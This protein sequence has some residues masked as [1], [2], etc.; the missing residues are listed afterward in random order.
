MAD[1]P[2]REATVKANIAA[3]KAKYG[4]DAFDKINN[5]CLEDISVSLALLVDGQSSGT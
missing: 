3:V 4:D 1:T 5:V 2:T